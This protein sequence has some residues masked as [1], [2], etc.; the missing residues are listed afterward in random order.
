MEQVGIPYEVPLDDFPALL[1]GLHAHGQHVIIE[2]EDRKTAEN[3]DYFIG[4]ILSVDEE[5]VIALYFNVLG[6]W[7]DEPSVIPHD[8]IT[9]IQFDTPYINIMSRYLE[10]PPPT[11]GRA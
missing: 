10:D 2:C 7:D 3:D 11:N 4:R 5:S 9:Q 6:E 8:D 1:R